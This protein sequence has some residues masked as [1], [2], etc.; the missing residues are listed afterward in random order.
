MKTRTNYLFAIL[1]AL[2]FLALYPARLFAEDAPA[3]RGKVVLIV[4]K[5]MASDPDVSWRIERLIN[6]LTGDGWRV[7]RHDVERGPEHPDDGVLA[8]Y[9][10]WAAENAPR[11]RE[12]RALIKADYDA[13][14]TEVKQVLLLGHIAV[15]YSGISSAVVNGG[16]YNWTGPNPADTFYGDMTSGYGGAGWTDLSTSPPIT[17]GPRWEFTNAPGDGK[18]DQETTPAPLKLAVGRVDLRDMDFFGVNEATLISRYLDKDHDFRCANFLVER[19]AFL[20]GDANGPFCLAFGTPGSLFGSIDSLFG[21]DNVTEI[22]SGSPFWFPDV[23]NTNYIYGY[24]GGFGGPFGSAENVGTSI[25]FAQTDS[26]V[27][28]VELNASFIGLWDEP[29]DLLRAVLA[30]PYDPANGRYG[31]GLTSTM[32]ALTDPSTNFVLGAPIGECFL[33][34]QTNG[35][36]FAAS[37]VGFGLMGDPTLRMHSIQNP[38]NLGVSATS[39]SVT[40]TWTVSPDPAVSGY[41]VYSAPTRRGP[42]VLVNS[43]GPITEN[44]YTGSRSSGVPDNFYMLR[45]VKMETTP[46]GS[47][48]NM[49]D[50]LIVNLPG[51]LTHYLS[52]VSQPANQTVAEHVPDPIANAAVFSVDAVGSDTAGNGQLKYQWYKDSTLLYDDCHFHGTTTSSLLISGVQTSDAGNYHVVVS[53]NQPSD[54]HTDTAS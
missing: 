23:S 20:G 8:G 13:A 31:Y 17:I 10:A 1:T 52:I 42:F 12:V 18:F 35:L 7:L 24:G 4:D 2:A 39:G 48:T 11:I 43:S 25:D 49:S 21:P 50:G 41:N 46:V 19:R 29:G 16:H 54:G 26:R 5:T 36:N 51:T 15:P 14:P 47:Y 9:T 44:S 22:C 30:S 28:F 40:L 45:A 33:N 37:N 27:V 3:Y 38:S 34:T 6:D 32:L 53:N